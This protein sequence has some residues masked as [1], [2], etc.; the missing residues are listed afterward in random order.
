[1]LHRTGI[2][3]ILLFIL[4]LLSPVC[5][6]VLA[7]PLQV[8]TGD[9]SLTNNLRSTQGELSNVLLNMLEGIQ[10]RDDVGFLSQKIDDILRAALLQKEVSGIGIHFIAEW[11]VGE[12]RSKGFLRAN[13]WGK[14]WAFH[15]P[16]IKLHSIS[17]GEH[18]VIFRDSDLLVPLQFNPFG[19]IEILS[20]KNESM[21]MLEKCFG[22]DVLDLTFPEKLKVDIERREQKLKL[23]RF[24]LMGLSYDLWKCL[25]FVDA[26][27]GTD[28]T[29]SLV[30]RCLEYEND[31][32]E[33]SATIK[34]VE[35]DRRINLVPTIEPMQKRIPLFLSRVLH[36]LPFISM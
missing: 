34:T 24:S 17:R 2:Q 25:T 30:L 21:I 9:T 28:E 31:Q 7:P 27:V 18:A 11:H 6:Y 14:F 8:E 20:R 1:M 32:L 22:N 29:E 19:E 5:A 26:I 3:G 36:R 10:N 33:L 16:K 13:E 4:I 15:F 23:E 35:P 12:V